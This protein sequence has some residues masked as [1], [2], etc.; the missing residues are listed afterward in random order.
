V[1]V[2]RPHNSWLLGRL[3]DVVLRHKVNSGSV[4]SDRNCNLEEELGKRVYL[5]RYPKTYLIES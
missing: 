3:S 2:R 1:Y 4:A 5:F